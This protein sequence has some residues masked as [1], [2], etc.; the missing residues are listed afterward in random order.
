MCGWLLGRIAHGGLLFNDSQGSSLV[1]PQLA[2][3]IAFFVD[4]S[5]DVATLYRSSP[6]PPALPVQLNRGHAGELYS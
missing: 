4:E 6:A 3:V 1:C 2:M 5:M